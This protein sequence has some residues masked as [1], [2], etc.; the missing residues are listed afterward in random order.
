VLDEPF[1]SLDRAVVRDL[2]T[3]VAGLIARSQATAVLVSHDPQDAARLANRVIL[4]V[5]RPVRIV[6]D[7]TLDSAPAQRSWSDIATYEDRIETAMLE[8]TP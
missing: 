3:L 8:A 1:V 6:A 2:Q 5:G 7:L 4:I